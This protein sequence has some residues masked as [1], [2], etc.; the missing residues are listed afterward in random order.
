MFINMTKIKYLLFLLSLFLL[1]GCNFL[2]PKKP[3]ALKINTVPQSTVFVDGKHMGTTPFES[4]DLEPGEITLKLVPEE[5]GSD[6]SIPFEGLVELTSGVITV[7]NHE[8]ASE[9]L[10]AQGEI[11]TMQPNNQSFPSLSVISRPDAAWVKLNGESQK[12]T[13]LVI[14]QVPEGEHQLVISSP[15]YVDRTINIKAQSGYRLIVDVQLAK[16]NI[17]SNTG[18]EPGAEASESAEATES[19]DSNEGD[20]NDTEAGTTTPKPTSTDNSDEPEIPYVKIN[21]TPTGWLR[22]RSE[23]SLA[24]DEV[25]KVDPGETFPLK[26]TQSGWYQ[27]ELDD[28]DLGW[29]AGQYAEKYE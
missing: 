5:Q 9:D 1:S 20:E 18:M 29:I 16:E 2:T 7:V 14:D 26:D 10:P 24:S 11:L 6:S 27:I 12:F 8:F 19:A 22:V 21:E 28:G 13:P 15:G 4:Q 23:P 25:T 3:A 17:D